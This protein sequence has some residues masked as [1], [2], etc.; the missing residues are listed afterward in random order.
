MSPSVFLR[1]AIALMI[2]GAGAALWTCW[3]CASEPT[4]PAAM[5]IRPVNSETV[6]AFDTDGDERADFW[7]FQRSDGRKHALAYALDNS[8]QPDQRIELG[9][10]D[11][12]K[13]PHFV[14]ALDGV[15]FELVDELYREGHFRF[16]HPPSRVICC[17]PAMTDLCLA[18]LFHAGR[19]RAF[20]A[21]Y[22]DRKANRVV[23]GNAG[24]LSASNSPWASKMDYR[25]SF[26]WDAKAYLSPQAV[27]EHELKGIVRTFGGIETGQGYAYTVA[28]AGLGTRGGREAILEYLRTIDRLC[29]QIIFERH[30][31]VQLTLTADHGH[32]LV[33]NRRVSFKEVLKAAGYRQTRSLRGPHDVVP[34][35]YGLVTYAAFFTSDPVGV[36]ECLAQHEDV[37]FAC[38]PAGDAIIVCDRGGRARVTRREGGF[39]Y[40][41]SAG[42]PLK[43]AEIIEEL[44]SAGRV[45]ADG[46]I[47]DAALFKATVE[48]YYPD[49]LRRIWGAFHELVESPPDLI[50]NLC[51]GACYGS[52]FFHFMI[53]EVTSTHGSLDGKSSTT[54]VLTTLGEL[55]P[56]MRASEVLPALEKLRSRR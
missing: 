16:F 17:F 33:E 42:D 25:C 55:P 23:S 9:A 14:I 10:I 54:F 29:E 6:F 44:R 52:R 11:A 41:S 38:Y 43:L 31:R 37:E 40:D 26:W 51:D 30:G 15:P 19:C 35:S 18:E 12:T 24:Y 46:V 34:I 2:S 4:F 28:T 56:A 39:A 49:P 47:D 13:C 36:A 27:F 20:Q 53:R 50:V 21:P 3:G 48:H 22:F 1:R 45:S 5:E 8:G 32:N 7:Q